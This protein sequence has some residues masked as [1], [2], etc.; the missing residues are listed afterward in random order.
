MKLMKRFEISKKE[1]IMILLV[2]VKGI[3]LHDNDD[4]LLMI[5]EVEPILILQLDEICEGLKIFF[6]RFDEGGE[7]LKRNLHDLIFQIFLGICD[8]KLSI[9]KVKLSKNQRKKILI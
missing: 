3:L 8:D 5:D 1:K 4:I 7:K 6:Q 9:R 2:V